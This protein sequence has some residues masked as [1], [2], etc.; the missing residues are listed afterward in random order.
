L[1]VIADSI[2]ASHYISIKVIPHRDVY[3]QGCAA[4]PL[5]QGERNFQSNVTGVNC[6][7]SPI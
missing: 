4:R 5:L 3:G 1:T 6:A 7:A 2:R